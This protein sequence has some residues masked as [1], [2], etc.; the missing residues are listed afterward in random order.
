MKNAS[1][2]AEVLEENN[3]YPFGLKHEGYNALTGDPN[4]HYEFGGKELQKE[5]G[6][7]DFGARM[8]M[9]DI[10]RW[11]VVD[12]MAEAEPSWTPYRYGFNNPILFTDPTGMIE[13]TDIDKMLNTGGSYNYSNGNLNYLGGGNLGGNYF[14]DDRYK[15]GYYTPAVDYLEFDI[16]QL[17]IN[18]PKSYKGNS[19]LMRLSMG[20]EIPKYLATYVGRQVPDYDPLTW[21]KNDGPIKYIGG[22]GDVTGVFEVGGMILSASD[23]KG[24]NLAAIPLLVMTRNG[25]DVLKLL[26]AEKGILIG[27]GTTKK[28][29]LKADFLFENSNDA[30]NFSSSMLGANKTRMYNE[31]GKWIGWKN[32]SE[33]AVYWG[34]GDWGKGKGSSTFPHINY[35]VNGQKGHFFLK[36]KI[37]NKGF[38]DELKKYFNL[39][40]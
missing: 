12:P 1:G 35:E 18:V 8:Y 38:E 9:S 10:G 37:K 33:D 26:A 20:M 17:T 5:T 23:N 14:I 28:G 32:S 31:R 16:P 34:H 11:G 2:S 36:D 30:K 25:D 19:A 40:N 24:M 7:N 13:Q 15:E 29:T 3:Y 22:A 21:V 39:G 27:T 4:Y 6:W